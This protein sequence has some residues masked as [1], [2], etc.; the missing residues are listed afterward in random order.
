MKF[1]RGTA[2]ELTNWQK[3]EGYGFTVA[4]I[5]SLKKGLFCKLIYND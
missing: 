1:V 3:T 4:V 2:Q 5:H